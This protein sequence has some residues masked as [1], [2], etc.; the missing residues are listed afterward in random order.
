[1]DYLFSEDWL[2]GYVEFWE[3]NE[4]MNVSYVEVGGDFSRIGLITSW[5]SGS[6]DIGDTVE[7]DWMRITL[8]F[9]WSDWSEECTDSSGCP[10]SVPEDA[11]LIQ[12]RVNLAT[13]DP[14]TTPLVTSVMLTDV[15]D[16]LGTGY[17]A[18]SIIDAGQLASWRDLKHTSELP[19]GTQI[20]FETRTGD[21][22]SPDTSWSQWEK[23][24]S[25][26]SSPDGRYMQ[27]RATLSTIDGEVTPTVHSITITYETGL[28]STGSAV[29]PAVLLGLFM[30]W[31]FINKYKKDQCS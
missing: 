12:Y 13:T 24:N 21:S 15:G 6:W 27:Y 14:D 11:T 1:M 3:N 4:W 18:S 22:A 23:V 19:A 17:F 30:C 10:I 9:T 2:G 16:Y 26:I 25:P 8:P 5:A 31:C 29:L 28:S 20:E 7:I